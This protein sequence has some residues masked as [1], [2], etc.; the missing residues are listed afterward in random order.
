M[1]IPEKEGRLFYDLFV[2]LL[3][4]TNDRLDIVPGLATFDEFMG[5]PVADR[6]RVRDALYEH[7]EFF[8][9]F[10]K[11]GDLSA[12]E[13]AA[14]L[15]AGW[16][17]HRL[18]GSFYV[19]R[20]LKKHTV[21]LSTEDP[22]R[23]FGVLWLADPPEL[24]VPYPPVMLDATLLPFRNRVIYDGYLRG[25][26]V[27]LH[28]GGGMRRALNNS[29]REAKARFGIITSLPNVVDD[30]A[31][32]EEAAA[33]ERLKV[34]VKS[35]ESRHM[36]WEEIWGLRERG[37]KFEKLYHQERGKAD[38]RRVGR[39]L[40]ERGIEEGWFALYEGMNIAS[41]TNRKE[42]A[43]RVREILPGSDS[44][45]PYLYQLKKKKKKKKKKKN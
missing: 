4:L 5:M 15:V 40:R 19:F 21:F 32:A 42:L 41:A 23:A 2:K 3:L 20:H 44:R 38:A 1:Q 33:M 11:D 8:D 26:G 34:L 16:R 31:E 28:F 12:S 35:A 29:Y 18:T 13:D 7:P 6:I 25:P 24:M 30:S 37:D 14:E 36:N 17:D 10:L 39:A 9:E 22:T 45:L 43:A 27:S